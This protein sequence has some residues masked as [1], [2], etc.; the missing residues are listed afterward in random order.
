M[1]WMYFSD[2]KGMVL[3][4]TSRKS[5]DSSVAWWARPKTQAGQRGP[6]GA[7]H[8]HEEQGQAQAGTSRPGEPERRQP[9]G[10]HEAGQQGE[11]GFQGRAGRS[12][13][14]GACGD[15]VMGSNILHAPGGVKAG[16]AGA[17]A[18][19]RPASR[20]VRGRSGPAPRPPARG[21]TPTLRP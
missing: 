3:A 14:R 9:R 13:A 6:L 15:G 8:L 7:G 10:D 12:A 21:V 17:N 20:T 18:A 4:G 2:S 16:G 19:R 1:A 5:Q 11:V